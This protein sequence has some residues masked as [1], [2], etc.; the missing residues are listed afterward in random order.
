MASRKRAADLLVRVNVLLTVEQIAFLDRRYPTRSGGMRDLVR[1]EMDR[2]WR[3]SD[4]VFQSDFEKVFNAYADHLIEPLKLSFL[5]GRK[6]THLVSS[7][8]GFMQKC[9]GKRAPDDEIE[10]FLLKKMIEVGI[11][12]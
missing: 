2:E 5:D 1:N 12:K 11:T 4:L 3:H 6:V 7:F 9:I 10:G 8:S